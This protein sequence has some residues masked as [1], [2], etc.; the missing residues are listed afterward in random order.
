MLPTLSAKG[1][2]VL[3]STIHRRGRGVKVGDCVDFEHPMVPG[4][5]AIKRVIGMPGD[6]VERNVAA[7]EMG[8]EGLLSKK[9][10]MMMQVCTNLRSP[11]SSPTNANSHFFR[12]RFQKD[13]AGSWET[14]YQT[15][16]IPGR[17]VRFHLLSSKEKLLPGFGQLRR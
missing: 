16:A 2:G 9:T 7:V 17:M 13:I 5:G 12:S 10:G 6:F 4:V 14:I 11:G 8:P 1:D 15:H 3:V